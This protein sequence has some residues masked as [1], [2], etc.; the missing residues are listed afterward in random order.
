MVP[1]AV[2]SP[3]MIEQTFRRLQLL[4]G[5]WS[6]SGTGDYPTIDAFSYSETLRFE[7]DASYPL[8]HYEQRAFLL[9]GGEP[10][11]WESGF[12]RP[13]PSG[14]VEFS[15]SQDSG[16]VEVLRGRPE[17]DEPTGELRL[18]LDSVLLGHDPRLVSTRRILSVRGD[19][20]RYEKL[21]ATTTTTRPELRRHLAAA[22][23]RTAD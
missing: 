20:L 9:P 15:S 16:R 4:A 12:I 14:E 23:D 18:V 10:S 11:H 2:C 19:R 21:M 6:G 13:L 8:F 17:T 5:T 1:D 7:P 3:A 22:L